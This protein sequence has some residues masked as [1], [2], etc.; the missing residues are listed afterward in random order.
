MFI[1]HHQEV[2]TVYVQQLVC[3]I[4][5][6]W[7]AAGQDGPSCPA[8]S[9]LKRITH[10]NCC[11]YTAI[12]S[13]WWAVNMPETCRGNWRNKL[14]IN[15]ASGW[16]SLHTKQENFSHQKT[17]IPS[18]RPTQPLIQWVPVYLSEGKIRRDVNFT[19]HFHQVPRGRMNGA[20]ALIFLYVFMAYIETTLYFSLVFI[21]AF[22]G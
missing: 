4:R 3:V 22:H 20:I 19:T 11:P 12:T 6:S 13:W 17:P 18:L 2:F 7:L 8:A 5:L 21:C 16:F 15:S 14:R 10:T 9:Q 1:A